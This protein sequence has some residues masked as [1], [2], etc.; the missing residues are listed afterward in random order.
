MS[1]ATIRPAALVT[2]AST[3]IG[4]EI[5]LAL[6]RADYDVAITARDAG[7]LTE[8]AQDITSAG[9]RVAPIALDLREEAS[10]AAALEAAVARLGQVDLVVNNAAR[11]LVKPVVETSWADWNDVT[12]TNL[13][14]AFFLSARFARTCIA[15][16][17]P[18]VIVNISSTHA[19]A[20][21][22]GRSVYGIA[23][24][25]LEQMTRMMA[26]EWARF[27]IRVNAVAPTTVMTPSRQ[28]ALSD[29]A[30]RQQML[31]RIPLGRFPD[32]SEVAAA[33]VYLASPAAASITGH[34]LLL[35]GGLTAQ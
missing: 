23:K 8:V 16:G 12:D 14:G 22:A 2:G 1:D 18:G 35:D 11:A 25:G 17:R 29:P 20:A 33:V 32:A 21:I 5:A 28:Q 30:R 19:Q 27:G 4:R 31:S 34:V 15:A 3:G 26:I 13:R 24:A 7:R 9:R 6:A 10:I